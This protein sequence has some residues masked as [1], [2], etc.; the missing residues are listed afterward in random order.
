MP[1]FS[2]EREIVWSLLDKTEMSLAT[3]G[4]DGTYAV[5]QYVLKNINQMGSDMDATWVKEGCTKVVFY[6]RKLMPNYVIKIPFM[7]CYCFDDNDNEEINDENVYYF[8]EAS[9][10]NQ[11]I[12]EW[13]YCEAES[14]L[15]TKA[16]EAHVEN[17]F[18]GT[19]FLGLYKDTYPIYISEY[20]ANYHRPRSKNKIDLL[21][22]KDFYSQFDRNYLDSFEDSLSWYLLNY[23]GKE[24]FAALMSFIQDWDITD[25]HYGNVFFTS[26]GELKI[27]DYSGYNESL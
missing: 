23:Y 26:N 27:I 21:A 8:D 20:I 11:N 25:L 5:N 15:Y 6:F 9:S 17:F 10:F 1:D 12:N 19:Y 22:L 18:A 13:D 14:F 4:S 3:Y 7:G 24:R 16:I 2:K